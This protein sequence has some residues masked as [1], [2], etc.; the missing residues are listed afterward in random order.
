MSL[1]LGDLIQLLKGTLSTNAN[2]VTPR[3]LFFTSALERLG[4]LP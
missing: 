1:G 4:S 2:F 3:D